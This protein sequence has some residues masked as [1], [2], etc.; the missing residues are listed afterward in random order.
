MSELLD[1]TEALQANVEGMKDL[2]DALARFN[3][4]FASWL[5]VMRMNALTVDW[6]QVRN[7]NLLPPPIC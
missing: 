1:E 6:I 3:E 7:P 5:Y 2:G 4:G